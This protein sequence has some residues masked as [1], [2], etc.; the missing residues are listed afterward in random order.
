MDINDLFAQLWALIQAFPSLPAA[1]KIS[2]II[3]LL[4][5]LIKSSLVAPLWEKLGSWKVVIAPALGLVAGVLAIHPLSFASLWQG[6]L[7]G[8]LAMGLHQLLD[9][10]KVIPGIG[11]VYLKVIDVL[12]TIFKAPDQLKEKVKFP[13]KIAKLSLKLGLKKAA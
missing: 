6:L 4:I 13:A 9:A 12:E 8:V 10:I 7:G 11:P 5:S 1:G 3:L 2:G